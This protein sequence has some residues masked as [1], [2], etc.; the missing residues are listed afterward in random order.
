MGRGQNP[1]DE[2]YT[3]PP[4]LESQSKGIFNTFFFFSSHAFVIGGGEIYFYVD[5]GDL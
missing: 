2:S 5:K 4:W 1:S 3:C